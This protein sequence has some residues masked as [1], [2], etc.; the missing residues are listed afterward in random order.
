MIIKYDIELTA[1][2]DTKVKIMVSI[3]TLPV[4]K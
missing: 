4:F 2:A 3:I 1:K